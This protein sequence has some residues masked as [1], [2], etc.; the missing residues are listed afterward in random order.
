ML[1]SQFT[2][3]RLD[4]LKTRQCYLKMWVECETTGDNGIERKKRRF[5]LRASASCILSVQQ[6]RDCDPPTPDDEG[7]NCVRL[8]WVA[9]ELRVRSGD[10]GG[11]ASKRAHK[12]K[13][14]LPI[15]AALP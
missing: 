8:S 13:D 11:R 10:G 2:C 5:D 6:P 9:K 4:G 14:L 3:F 12:S 15:I 1:W 7:I